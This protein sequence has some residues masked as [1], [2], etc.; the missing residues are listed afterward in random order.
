MHTGSF[1]PLLGSY[2]GL[3]G[4]LTRVT[5]YSACLLDVTVCVLYEVAYMRREGCGTMRVMSDH[6]APSLHMD[7][8]THFPPAGSQTLL[9][10]TSAK[11]LEK[12]QIQ[13]NINN[14]LENKCKKSFF[15]IQ[16]FENA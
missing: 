14:I 9:S 6:L 5:P 10:I 2:A 11:T 7:H 15:L 12:Q 4:S 16:Y 3:E 1:G 8:L 13:C